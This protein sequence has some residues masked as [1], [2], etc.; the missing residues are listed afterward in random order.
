MS[1]NLRARLER[2]E[3][4]AGTDPW[5]AEARAIHDGMAWLA[6][7]PPEVIEQ[8]QAAADRIFGDGIDDAEAAAVLADLERRLSEAGI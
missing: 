8:L 5:T 1:A 3:Q 6:T 2:L 7:Q 4:D